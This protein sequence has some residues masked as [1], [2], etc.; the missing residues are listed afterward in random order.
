MKAVALLIS[1]RVHN[2]KSQNQPANK[3]PRNLLNMQ[4]HAAYESLLDNLCRQVCHIAHPPWLLV[5]FGCKLD[6]YQSLVVVAFWLADKYAMI[7]LTSPFLRYQ[8]TILRTLTG[9]V[10]SEIV[11]AC[12]T[13]QRIFI[14][15]MTGTT[16]IND[17]C[18]WC[19]V[20]ESIS[21]AQLPED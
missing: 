5:V 16:N 18:S 2:R 6:I 3:Q 7:F 10:T 8:T 14:A 12:L 13:S 20:S 1:D 17:T 21:L 15:A 9:G 4:P 11:V 19:M